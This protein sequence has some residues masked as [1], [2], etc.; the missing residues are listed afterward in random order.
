MYLVAALESDDTPDSQMRLYAIA[1]CAL[2]LRGAVSL[3]SRAIV[4]KKDV[5]ELQ[6]HCQRFFNVVSTLLQRVNPI[7]WT[8]GYAIPYQTFI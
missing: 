1:Y 6:K 8:V 2:E 5:T 3:F 4:T 7:V